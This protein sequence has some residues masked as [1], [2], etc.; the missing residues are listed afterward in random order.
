MI[1][2]FPKQISQRAVL[3]YLASLAAVSVFFLSNA[4][5]FGYMAL[6]CLW[7]FSFFGLVTFCSKEWL[8]M[9]EKHYVELIFFIALS[10]RII[11]VI[12][13][14]FYYIQATGIPFEHNTADALGYHLD[15]EWLAGEP[16]SATWGY[17]FGWY[18]GYADSGFPFYLTVIYK[19]FGPSIIVVRL[20]NAF[21]SSWS[22][23][24]VY[25]LSSRTFGDDTGRMA[26]I[27][28]VFM[29]NLIMYCGYHLKE[30]LM[31]FLEVACLDRIDYLARNKYSFWNVAL[32]VLLAVSMFFF[33]TA[34]GASAVFAFVSTILLS[35][36]PA[37]KKGSKR[38]ALIAW[39]VLALVV[40]GGGTIATEVEGL[41]EDREENVANKRMEQTLRGNQWAKYA[42]GTVMAPMVFTLPFATMVDVDQQYSQQAK[43][44]GNYV[45][46]FM[47]FFALIA[48]YEAIRR[49]K[50]REFVTIGAFVIAYLGVVSSSGFSNSERFLLPG[51]PCLIM[52][53]A[54]GVS[55]LR[56]KTYKLL[57]PWCLV[58][59][60]MEVGWAY[61]KLGSRGLF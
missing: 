35:S 54:Y 1:P 41:W 10:I 34:F 51:L 18:K 22:C 37:M 8:R 48:I 52:M 42:T 39:S 17:L 31:L 23:V 12:A 4:M 59:L 13:S 57:T 27:M 6:G 46:N 14:Y 44:G 43:S 38:V 47:G 9:P 32:P 16:W 15:A 11:W 61:F 58:V 36:S 7:V 40:F 28:M 20:L 49:K 21:L 50:W 33:R 5:K 25:R 55:A 26:G 53:W 24:I 30:T 3:V 45:R 60:A 56:D 19:L 29:P 2:F